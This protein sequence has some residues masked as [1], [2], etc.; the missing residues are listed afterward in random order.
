LARKRS[1]HYAGSRRTRAALVGLCLTG[2]ALLV[3]LDRGFVAPQWSRP[4]ASR[5]QAFAA[6]FAQYHGRSFPVVHVVDGDTL[7]LGVPD[8]SGPVT[9][10]RLIGID[11][12]ELANGGR[13]PMYFGPEAAAFAKRLAMGKTVTVYLD[14]R[15]G[16]RDRYGR[17]LA[18]LALPDGKFL[19]EELLL[20]GY[21][22]ADPR[23]RHSYYQKYQQL[24]ASARALKKGLWAHVTPEQMP[25]WR[26]RKR[27]ADAGAD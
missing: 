18:Y 13:K 8:A 4:A 11:T 23:F 25:P 9:K 16:S 17:L 21:A 22:Y 12:P 5:G 20:E 15:A 2:A 26:Q 27:P 10:V 3:A 6:D 7:H 1:S 14:E 19:N 24:E